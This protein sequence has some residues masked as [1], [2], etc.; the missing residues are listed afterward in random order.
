MGLQ[1]KNYFVDEA[2][3]LTLFNKRGK[4]ILGSEGVS[5]FFMLGVAEISELE[6]FKRSSI[7]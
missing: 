7:N 4:I 1:E 2:G 3:D 6:I 5:N